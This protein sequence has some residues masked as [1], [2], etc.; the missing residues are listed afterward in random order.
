MPYIG[1]GLSSNHGRKSVK[2]L[3]WNYLHSPGHVGKF[4]DAIL[5]TQH[6]GKALREIALYS[7][8]GDV[9]RLE[10]YKIIWPQI[11]HLLHPNIHYKRE[12]TRINFVF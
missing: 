3:K 1:H 2:V 4:Y 5:V 7:L 12:F 11:V 8:Y 6:G 9:Y 10:Q